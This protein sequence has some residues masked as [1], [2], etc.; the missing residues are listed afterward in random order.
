MIDRCRA[1]DRVLRFKYYSIP[2][3][4]AYAAPVGQLPISYWDKFGRPPVEQTSGLP[5]LVGRHRWARSPE[6]GRLVARGVPVSG[7]AAYVL[8][9]LLPWCRR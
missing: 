4:H 3:Q 8:R 5:L 1:V 7:M 9:R 2:L 6:A